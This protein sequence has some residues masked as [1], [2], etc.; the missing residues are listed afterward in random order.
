MWITAVFGGSGGSE[1]IKYRG[2]DYHSQPRFHNQACKGGK[3]MVSSTIGN[4]SAS[5][6]QIQFV[7][8]KGIRYCLVTYNGETKTLSDWAAT[9]GVARHFL[10]QRLFLGKKWSVAD[11]FELVRRIGEKH[12]KSTTG[13]FFV[14]QGIWRRCGNPNDLSFKNY[15]GRG[16]TVCNRWIRFSKFLEDVGE[17]PSKEHSLDRIDND[18]NYEPGNVRWVTRDVQ[19]RNNRR[20]RWIVFNG[21]RKVLTDWANDLGINVYTLWGRIYKEGWSVEKALTTPVRQRRRK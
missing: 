21:Q 16:I 6:N 5:V 18:G 12:G 1:S 11:A 19:V 3:V 17:R 15:G 10:Y 9:L 4:L 20:N 2:W 8:V 14:W 13:E 7:Q